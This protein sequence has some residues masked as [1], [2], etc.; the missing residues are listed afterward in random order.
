MG[1]RVDL[2]VRST[3]HRQDVLREQGGAEEKKSFSD[4]ERWD[5]L[6]LTK[7]QEMP[8]RVTVIVIYSKRRSTHH[9]NT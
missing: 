4:A 8:N 3:E 7:T 5:H 2:S 6:H 1:P 9:F